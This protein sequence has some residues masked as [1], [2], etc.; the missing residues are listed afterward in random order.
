[1]LAAQEPTPAAGPDPAPA[2][3]TGQA[4]LSLPVCKVGW[5]EQIP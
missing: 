2:H 4:G 3:L 1:M 5:R